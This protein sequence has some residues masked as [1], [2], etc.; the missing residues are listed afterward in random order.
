MHHCLKNVKPGDVIHYQH[1]H[2]DKE[3]APWMMGKLYFY[4]IVRGRGG[5]IMFVDDSEGN[6]AEQHPMENFIG[7]DPHIVKIVKAF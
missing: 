5:E 4:K 1:N 7:L 2:V 3:L 6:D